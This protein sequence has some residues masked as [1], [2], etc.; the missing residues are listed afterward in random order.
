VILKAMDREPSR[1]YPTAQAL[2]EDLRRFLADLPIRARPLSAVQRLTRWV[3]RSPALAA[4]LVV[5]LVLLL[6]ALA[7]GGFGIVA[8]A[9]RTEAMAKQLEAEGRVRGELEGRLAEAARRREVE[10]ERRKFES[11]SALLAVQRG[12]ARAVE[13]DFPGAAAWAARALEIVPEE[14]ADLER[15]IRLNLAAF[16]DTLQPLEWSQR[17]D[18][19]VVG[20]AFDRTGKLMATSSGD[21][22]A[23]VWDVAT[24]EG[25]GPVLIQQFV[26]KEISFSPDSKTLLV[27]TGPDVSLWDYANARRTRN[28][29]LPTDTMAFAFSPDGDAYYTATTRGRVSGWDAQTGNPVGKPIV[30]PWLVL[31]LGFSAD[32]K[33]ILIGG[34]GRPS[35]RG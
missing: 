33:Q 30:L 4:T 15:H 24:G 34:E 20:V 6:T 11:L 18:D 8:L 9:Q 26:P 27:R 12:Q 2:A 19:S 32:G 31:A 21:R 22:R 23:R 13:L 35:P 14:D 29:P 1:R 28:H 17:H 16:A 7:A 3:R 5:A 10:A 25:V